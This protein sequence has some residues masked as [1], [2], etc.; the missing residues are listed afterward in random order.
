MDGLFYDSGPELARRRYSTWAV[1]DD[2]DGSSFRPEALHA[3]AAS[4]LGAELIT[5]F[6][7]GR[8]LPGGWLLLNGPVLNLGPDSVVPALAG[9]R[10]ER[11]PRLPRAPGVSL[12]PDWVCEVLSFRAPRRANR[13]SLYAREGVLH[14]WLVDPERRMLEVLRLDGHRYVLL[15]AHAGHATVRAEPFEALDL[16]LSLLWAE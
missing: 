1:E 11:L 3:Y 15:G 13:L 8:G 7:Q 10:R 4:Q 9:W 14:L 16:R 12:T 2:S 5:T 6:S